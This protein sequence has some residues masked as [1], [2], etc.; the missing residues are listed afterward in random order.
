MDAAQ[1][2]QQREAASCG[3]APA[4]SG[5]FGAQVGAALI[6][7]ELAILGLWVSLSWQPHMGRPRR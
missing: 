7:L 2:K 3:R 4:I 1:R 5:A 6:V